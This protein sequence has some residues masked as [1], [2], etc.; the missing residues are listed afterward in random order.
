MSWL[1]VTYLQAAFLAVVNDFFPAV[2]A[3]RPVNNSLKDGLKDCVQEV[4][5]DMNLWPDNSFVLKVSGRYHVG[6]MLVSSAYAINSINVSFYEMYHVR[7]QCWHVQHTLVIRFYIVYGD[8][9]SDHPSNTFFM[10][11]WISRP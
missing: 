6:I 1:Y 5:E 9:E 10:A 11:D 2:D 8:V 7:Q 3:P 4:C